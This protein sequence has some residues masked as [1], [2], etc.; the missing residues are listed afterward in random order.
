MVG[1]V[2]DISKK[3]TLHFKEAGDVIFVLGEIYEDI[4]CSEYLH[5]IVGV[6]YSPAPHFDLEEEYALQQLISGLIKNDLL[7]SAHDI[8]EGGLF[9]TLC[10]SAFTNGLGFDITTDEKIRKDAFLFGE[11]QSRVVVSVKQDK[12]QDFQSGIKGVKCRKVGKVT[13]S[14]IIIDN[15]QWKSILSFKEQYESAIERH[16]AGLF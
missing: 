11:G 7:Q 13:K 2:D 14:D 5:K 12:T 15:S 16:L 8:S 6:E 9:V 1:L 10:E 3:M 4:A